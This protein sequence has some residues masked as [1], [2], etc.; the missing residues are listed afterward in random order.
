MCGVLLFWVAALLLQVVCGIASLRRPVAPDAPRHY[1]SL[2]L[3]AVGGVTPAAALVLLTWVFVI[4]G[5]SNVA[6]FAANG[7]LGLW[8]LW[9][10]V[11]PVLLLGNGVSVLLNLAALS[12]PPYPSV[13]GRMFASRVCGLVAAGSAVLVLIGLAPDA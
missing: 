7:G 2:V 3:S 12:L 6:Q 4:G 11:W 5:S 1:G 9:S 8:S 13:D 10:H